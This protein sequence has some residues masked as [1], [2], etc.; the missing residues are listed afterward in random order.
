MGKIFNRNGY[1]VLCKECYESETKKERTGL[2]KA[3]NKELWE[4]EGD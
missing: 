3:I 1:S 4:L 2:P